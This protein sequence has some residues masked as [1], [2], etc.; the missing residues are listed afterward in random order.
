M[1]IPKH[2]LV[3]LLFFVT[4][5][6]AKEIPWQNDAVSIQAQ[7][8]PVS[9]FLKDFF[10][11]Q[12][13]TALV[14]DSVEGRISG[15]F[16]AEPKKIFDDLVK[17]YGLLPYYDGRV[18]HIA[19]TSTIQSRSFTLPKAK[20]SQ[21]V[22]SL[23]RQDLADQYQSIRVLRSER[24]VKV[25]GAPQFIQDVEEIVRAHKPKPKKAVIRVVEESSEPELIFKTF[26][27]KYASAADVVLFQGGREF[28]IPGVASILRSMIG[29]GNQPAATSLHFS[30]PQDQTIPGLRGKGL[31]RHTV[32]DADNE[33][34]PKPL[35]ISTGG[36]TTQR[37]FVTRIEAERNLNAVIVRDYA[38]SMPLYAQLIHQL[39]QEPLLIEIQVTI[40][41]VDKSKLQDLGVNWQYND[42]NINTTFGGGNV[43]NQNGGILFNTVLGETGR[44]LASVNALASEGSA[45]VV[46]RPQVITLSNLEAVLSSDQQFFVRIAGLE[47]VDLFNVTVGTSL[48]VVPNVVGDSDDPQIRLLVAIEDGSIVPDAAVDEIPVVEKATLNT[49]AMIYNGE[50]LLL[51]GLVR[52]STSV[53]ERGVPGLKRIPGVGRLF[54][55]K[56][57]VAI[58]AERLFLITPKIISGQRNATRS[59]SSRP[60]YD[61]QSATP[62]AYLDGF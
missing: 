9:A 40:I 19:S 43:G 42:S 30:Q 35:D 2:L 23:I 20:V 58:T 28:V 62:K 33:A 3:F 6:Q 56:T 4:G 54:K 22:N 59:T 61:V 7:E 37:D 11:A 16:N 21:V 49:Q 10:N 60:R 47:Q 57:D 34:Q 38:D 55:R 41:D 39:D 46:S 29:D 18:V 45:N 5:A 15:Q 1:K 13:L 24:L 14:S 53:D 32:S 50:S 17:A 31:R 48:R 8:Q 44:F 27:L 52:E 25:R 51:G 36:V 12:G 26:Q